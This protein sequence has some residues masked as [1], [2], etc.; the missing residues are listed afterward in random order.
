MNFYYSLVYG[1]LSGKYN[2]KAWYGQ[3]RQWMN[4]RTKTLCIHCNLCM[5]NV[6]CLME[7][8]GQNM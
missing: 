6:P 1:I 8:K 2:N 4:N 5:S 3:E 7:P